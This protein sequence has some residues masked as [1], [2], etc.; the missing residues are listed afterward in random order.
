MFRERA[1]QPI[2]PLHYSEKIPDL[3]T[4]LDNLWLANTTQIYPEDRGTN[5]AV[6]LGEQVSARI[7]ESI[8]N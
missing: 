4:P 1:A 2:T 8:K 3:K 6:R 5:Y 7:L